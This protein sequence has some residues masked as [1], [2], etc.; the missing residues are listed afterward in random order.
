MLAERGWE[1]V[2]ACPP[3]GDLAATAQAAGARWV[4]WDATRSPGR[5]SLAEARALARVVEEVRPDVVHLHS[6]KAGLAGRLLGRSGVPVVLT[7]HAWSWHGTSGPVARAARTWERAAARRADVVLCCGSDE[8]D[9]GVAAG[10]RPHRWDVLANTVDPDA[11][12][13]LDRAAARSRLG[14][15][16]DRA[17]VVCAARVSHQKGQ[18]VLFEAWRAA[19]PDA[20]LVLVGA[21]ADRDRILALA[22]PGTV[23]V[24]PASRTDVLLWCGAADLVVAP[25]RYEGL[26]LAA[27]EAAAMGA[28]VLATDVGGMREALT[29]TPAR[30]L[31]TEDALALAAAISDGLVR[32]AELALTATSAAADLRQRLRTRWAD[33]ADHLDRLYR[34]LVIT[35]AP[36]VPSVAPRSRAATSARPPSV[37]PTAPGTTERPVP[38]AHDRA[39]RPDVHHLT[40]TSVGG[41][42]AGGS[43]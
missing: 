20:T 14:V 37:L 19:A 3:G 30:L 4:R 7:P 16:A 15:P 42:P 38:P 5:S 41:V 10:V 1:S 33:N 27:L 11:L 12:P 26:S 6:S 22:P 31:P 28:P 24:V 43:R 35:H 9:E 17:V 13:P 23:V 36:V 8:V 39:P 25:S 40:P 21:V 32:R 18:D 29:G 2:V 34:E